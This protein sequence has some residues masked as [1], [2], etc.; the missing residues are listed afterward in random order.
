MTSEL[1]STR[2]GPAAFSARIF[3]S[4]IP[5]RGR[6][7]SQ[8]SKTRFTQP[9]VLTSPD[10]GMY[11]TLP[12][13][14]RHEG[15]VRNKIICNMLELLHPNRINYKISECLL[16]RTEYIYIYKILLIL[17]ILIILLIYIN[18]ILIKYIHILC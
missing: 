9:I 11:V 7:E 16:T 3:L 14:L 6:L 18:K 17:L 1:P 12:T 13:T 4:C 15:E 5:P 10:T 2:T 8:S